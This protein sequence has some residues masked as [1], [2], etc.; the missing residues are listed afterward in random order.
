MSIKFSDMFNSSEFNLNNPKVEEIL[1]KTRDVAEQVGKKSAEHLELSRKKL[2]CLDIKAKLMKQ[3]EKFGRIHY[4]A[5]IG[6]EVEQEQ[7]EALA[8]E[9]SALNDKLDML[10]IEIEEAKA[11]VE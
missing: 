10:N 3:Y 8:A 5:F 1:N 4:N 11:T 2:E 7:I 6:E 9:I